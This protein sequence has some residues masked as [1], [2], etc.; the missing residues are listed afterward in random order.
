[1]HR[2][3]VGVVPRLRNRRVGPGFSTGVGCWSVTTGTFR[4]V[5]TELLER[6]TIRYFS[7]RLL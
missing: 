7:F 6:K 5:L 4:T 2:K 3:E 1:L